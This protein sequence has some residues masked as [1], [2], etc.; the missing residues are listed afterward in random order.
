MTTN[1]SF[2]TEGE[3]EHPFPTEHQRYADWLADVAS[4]E[5]KTIISLTYIFCS[6][7]YLLGINQKY[8]N[9]DYYTDIITFPYQEGDKVES[10]LFIS[11][12]RVADN[13]SEFGVDFSNELRRVMVHGLL[14]LIGYGDKSDAEKELMQ[15]KE[16][17]YI[18]QIK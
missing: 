13:A 9:H 12:E 6:D 16:D 1:I 14:H 5:N 7:E 15:K 2:F 18:Q 17:F 8:L 3:I 10:D 11:I 4:S